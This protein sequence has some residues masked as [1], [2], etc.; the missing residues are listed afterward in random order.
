MAAAASS[1]RIDGGWN[2]SQIFTIPPPLPHALSSVYQMTFYLRADMADAQIDRQTDRRCIS[3]LLPPT[4][5]HAEPEIVKG[6]EY[7]FFLSV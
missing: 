2:M 7:S 3:C 4:L 5:L 6:R 1:L